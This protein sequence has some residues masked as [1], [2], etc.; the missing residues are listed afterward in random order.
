MTIIGSKT[1][2]VAAILV[3]LTL[4]FFWLTRSNALTE[5][6]LPDHQPDAV[7]GE[8]LFWAGGCASCHATPVDGRR[9]KGEDR[10]LLGGGEI[11][12]TPFGHFHVPNISPHP[13]DGIGDWTPLDFVNAMQRGVSPDGEHYYPSFP[14][15]S[16][17]RMRITDVL[18]LKAYIDTLP[19]VAG[20]S[21]EHELLFPY[22]IRR[23]VG[24]WKRTNLTTDWVIDGDATDAQFVLGRELVEGVGHCGEC[25]TPRDD[26]GGLD[27]TRWLAGAPNLEGEGR[28]PDLTPASKTL[29]SWTEDDIAYY[30]A[31]GF[32]P[33]F[34]SVGGTMVAVQENMAQLS[35][36]DRA[37][38]A[39][40]LK[41]LP[42][43][44]P[45]TQ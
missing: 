23:G 4:V 41:A 11:L 15:P 30:L 17:A 14:Y 40:Y 26:A 16:Y 39:A 6:E 5:G 13:A 21:D 2:K 8:R 36:A 12:E 7:A 44:E 43:V 18:N 34:D 31:S 22:S 28:I 27:L 37:A 9:A 45:S 35:D 10:L 33:D 42:T 24:L 38:I 20:S 19:P 3:A 25:H 29:S 1:S 32:T